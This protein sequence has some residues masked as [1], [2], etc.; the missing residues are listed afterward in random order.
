[1]STPSFSILSNSTPLDHERFNAHRELEGLLKKNLRGPGSSDLVR[2]D[3]GSRA[4]YAAD[5]SNYRQIPIGVVFP[6]DAAD[7]EAAL[8]ACRATGAAVLPRGAGTS[9]AGQ[10]VNVAVV[11]DYSRHM[12]ALH[13]IDVPSKV[14][15]VQPGIVLDRLRDAAEVHHLTYAPDPATH[16]RCTLGGIIGNN[17]CG[18]HGLLG[19]KAVDNT[20]SLDIVLYDGTRLTVGATTEDQLTALIRGGGRV[21]QLYAGLAQIRDRYAS[22]IR[23]KFPRIPRR[24]SG[25]NLDELLP[26][27]NFHVARAL[28]GSE[29]TCANIVS[30]TLNLTASP[31]FRVL[32]VLGFRDPFFAADA[33]PLAL[34]HKPIGLE[35][36]DFLLVDFMRRKGLALKQLDQLP[37]GVGFLLVEMG[38]WSAEEAQAKAQAVARASQSWPSSP[39]AHICTPEEAASVWHVRE[40]ALGAMVFV[41]GE[42]ERWEGWEDAAVPPA[43][44]G[45]YLR[46]ITKL[47]AEYGYRSPLY[48]HYGQ[49]CVH[50]RINFDFRTAEGVRR[51]REF[52]ERAAEVVLSFGGSLSGEHGDGQSRA[53]LLPKMFGPELIGAF[54]EFKTLWDPDNRMNPGKL[55]DAVRVYDPVENLRF[56][57]PAA[58]V[59]VSPESLAGAPSYLPEAVGHP[60]P[61]HLVTWDAHFAFTKDNGSLERATERCVGVGA[62]RNTQG[63]VMCPSYRATGEEQHSTRGRAHLLWEML[64]GALRDEGFKSDAVHEALDLC[65]SC[66]ACKTECPVQVD[67]AA[68]KSEFLAQR[69][70]GRLHPL[71]HYIFGFADQLARYGSLLPGLTNAILTGPV[72]SPLV[73]RIAGVAHQRQLPR[74]AKGSFQSARSLR[75]DPSRPST[76]RNRESAALQV[77]A[78]QVLLWP[79]TWNNYYHPQTLSA[80]ETV[81]TA[82]G[83][84]VETPRG[85][86]CCGRPLYDFGLLGPA[87]TYLERVLARMAPQI[88]A[89]LPFIFLEPSC[90]SVFKDE[91]LELFPNDPRAQRLSRQVWL[92]ADFL[93][94]NAGDFMSQRLDGAQIVVHGHC[95]HKAVFGGSA[96]EIALLRK[97]GA[98]VTA[99]QAGCC[100]MAGS[101]GFEAGKFDVSKTIANQELLPA[102]EAAGPAAIVVADGFSCRE[103]IEQLGH[104]QA[105]HFAEVLAR[106]CSGLG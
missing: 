22:L 83:F 81:L 76:D 74:L 8:A 72:T 53:A 15:R 5:A 79:D 52:I 39:V 33:V 42:P 101:F 82:A 44:L 25:Y 34:E 61:S 37:D 94:A 105:L 62:C 103:Q 56:N 26:E 95:H 1:M 38:A 96:S 59:S 75:R 21:G 63:G 70:K 97:T 67:M 89:G 73:K 104:R 32:V 19:G 4:L 29:G 58:G 66:K 3:L 93:A 98:T 2:F 47:M 28:V 35:G 92:L 77:S 64:A 27:N 48:G 87:R 45:S 71:H 84:R 80:A 106:T 24:V 100:G 54:R 90:A 55:S 6:R 65:L 10:C 78:P 12:N 17:S 85:H 51:F 30:A 31:P 99:I 7:V 9:L 49:G 43:Q 69:Y 18:V 36:F 91:L 46:A 86:I 60:G 40:S 13:S 16:S 57:P 68:Y 50:T 102:V 41:P 23:E 88:D 14:A 20:E 11:F